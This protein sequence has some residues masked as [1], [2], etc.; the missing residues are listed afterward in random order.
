YRIVGP[1][2]YTVT[3]LKTI[4][5]WVLQRRFKAIPGVIDVTG[6]GGKTKSYDIT[7]D[8][9]RLQAHGL[10]LKQVLDGLNNANVNVGANTVNIGPQSAIVRS[11]GQI[12]SMDDIRNTMLTASN[13]TPVLIS[14]IA[15][16]TVGHEP[17]LGVAGQDNDDDI[18]Q[19]IV[20]MRR[21]AQTLPTL[22]GVLAEVKKINQSG[23]LPP[24]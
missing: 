12:H 1:P 19:G 10:T 11:V 3:D 9:A 23:I 4:Q 7:V 14:D 16:V 5:D 22:A 21:G 18:V 24:G 15:T 13:G 8:L 20:L 6:W 17:R 2:G